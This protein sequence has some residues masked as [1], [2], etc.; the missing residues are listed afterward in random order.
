MDISQALKKSR[1]LKGMTQLTLA[2]QAGIS[3]S[4]LS[5]LEQGK[6]DPKLTLLTKLSNAIGIPVAILFFLAADEK[7]LS[8]LGE[9]LSKDLT[10]TAWAFLKTTSDANKNLI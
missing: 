3:A 8:G 7:E 6:R 4:Y 9:Q 5:Q 10:F 1:E 2:K